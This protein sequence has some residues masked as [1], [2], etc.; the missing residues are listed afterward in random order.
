MM[1]PVGA[2]VRGAFDCL[3]IE[4]YLLE[5]EKKAKEQS[6]NGANMRKP[7]LVAKWLKIVFLKQVVKALQGRGKQRQALLV[8]ILFNGV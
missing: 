7:H 2:N 4:S 8:G 1:N 3:I 6:L 5:I